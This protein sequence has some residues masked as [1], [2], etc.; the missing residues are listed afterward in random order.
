MREHEVSHRMPPPRSPRWHDV[1]FSPSVYHEVG[2]LKPVLDSEPLHF[3]L[4]VLRVTRKE[5]EANT[6][7]KSVP[8]F[9]VLGAPLGRSKY[10]MAIESKL[11]N[12]HG[13]GVRSIPRA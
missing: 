12:S 9:I 13:A 2:A 10:W 1:T 4:G 7:L 8:A 3:S 5:A 6:S 11:P